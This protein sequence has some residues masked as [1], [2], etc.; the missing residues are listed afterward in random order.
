MSRPPASSDVFRAVAD[1]TRRGIIELLATGDRT[2]GA[3]A[4]QFDLCHSTVSEHLAVLRRAALVTYEERSGRRTYTLTATPLREVAT[5]ANQLALKTWETKL[6]WAAANHGAGHFC[7]LLGGPECAGHLRHSKHR[8]AV[9]GNVFAVEGGGKG[10]AQLACSLLPLG[11]C[12]RAES[13]VFQ[14]FDCVS[15]ILPTS[16]F[17]E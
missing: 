15:V 7:E 10:L 5:W 16:T 11:W 6:G 13:C 17:T 3:I 2:A 12:A 14:K 1:P 4:R 9:V 8:C